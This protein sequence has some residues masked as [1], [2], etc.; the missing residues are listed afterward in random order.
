VQERLPECNE[1]AR[2]EK[3]YIV[4]SP[5]SQ[6][7]ISTVYICEYCVNSLSLLYQTAFPEFVETHPCPPSSTCLLQVCINDDGKIREGPGVH[8]FEMLDYHLRDQDPSM[9]VFIEYCWRWSCPESRI[10]LGLLITWWG[11]GGC[12]V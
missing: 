1:E 5:Q 4:L 8:Y 6:Q 11:K 9:D 2:G 3:W 12:D 7:P 10:R